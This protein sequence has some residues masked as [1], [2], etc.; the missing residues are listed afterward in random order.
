M[1]RSSDNDWFVLLSTLD[2]LL[3]GSGIEWGKRKKNLPGSRAWCVCWICKNVRVMID[4]SMEVP[5]PQFLILQVFFFFGIFIA[6]AKAN[7]PNRRRQFSI[8]F[9]F[10]KCQLLGWWS[11]ISAWS[12]DLRQSPISDYDRRRSAIIL[13]MRTLEAAE[14][15][16]GISNKHH[17]SR[18]SSWTR[19]F[20]SDLA[21]ACPLS[22]LHQV[23]LA[24]KLYHPRYLSSCSLPPPNID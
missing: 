4:Y 18:L 7:F 24:L 14:S 2:F 10:F 13:A 6:V 1:F 21:C 12:T 20:S 5:V 16:K 9:F 11:P 15:G 17:T 23:L 19:M 8:R 22:S 3:S